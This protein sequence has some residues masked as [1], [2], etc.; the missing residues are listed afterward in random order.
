MMEERYRVTIQ[1]QFYQ[2]M[3]NVNKNITVEA[4]LISSPTYIHSITVNS[5][6]ILL[7]ATC[8]YS[9]FILLLWL[10]KIQR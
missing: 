4:K 3:S 6:S 1:N 2:D 9:F 10:Q 8:Y 7:Y 5:V